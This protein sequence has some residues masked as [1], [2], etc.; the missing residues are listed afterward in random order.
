[1]TRMANYARDCRSA[2][3]CRDAQASV[4]QKWAVMA[5]GLAAQS[6]GGGGSVQ[7]QI[8]RQIQDLGLTFR[9]TGDADERPWPLTPMPLIVGAAE[10]GVVEAG[11]IQRAQLLEALAADIYGDQRL[12]RDGH[13]PAAVIAGSRYFARQMVGLKPQGG[14]YLRVCAFD[15]ARGPTGE[16]RILTDRLRLATGIGYAL[17]NRLALSRSTGA[18][19]DDINVRRLAA[20][21]AALREGMAQGC[22]R[23]QPRIALLT[24]ARFNQSYPEQAHLARYLGL[25]L[26]EGRD[27]T[28]ANDRLFVRT[29]AGPRRIDAVWRWI[30]TDALD[31]LS[32]DA[33][34]AI[35]VPD[36]FE[37]WAG[38]GLEMANWPGVEVMESNAFAA[39]LPKLCRVLLGEVALLPNVATWWCGQP[40]E[41][42]QVLGRLDELLVGPAFGQPVEVLN[43][44]AMRPGAEL[45][46]VQRD[47]LA[48]AVARRAMDYV[49]QE[50][51]HLSTSPVLIADRLVPRPFTLRAFAV[52][53]GDGQWTVMPGGFARL[54]SSGA[55]LTSLMGEGDLSADVCIVDDVPGRR[56][57]ITTIATI[58]GAP[59]VRRGG[60]ILA[61]Q[62]A[63]NLYWFGRYCERAEVTLRVLRSM[64]GSSIEADAGVRRDLEL[65]HLLADLLVEWDAIPETA[66]AGSLTQMCSAALTESELAGGVATLIRGGQR[67][68]LSLRDRLARD[69]WRIARRPPPAFDAASTDGARDAVKHLVERFGT[70]AGLIAENMVRDAA[71]RFLEIGRRIERAMLTCHIVR[72]LEIWADRTDAQSMLLDLCDSQII[73]RSRYLSAP[74]RDP[75]YDLLLLDPDNPRAL[76]FQLEAIERHVAALPSLANDAMPERPLREVRA[77]LA[78]LRGL[79]VD[80]L[81][82]AALGRIEAQLLALSDTISARYFLPPERDA[83]RLAGNLLG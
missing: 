78:P 51:V 27:L 30:D 47:E 41:A 46:A 79:T 2:D 66:T 73:Y 34:S 44:T 70:L 56:P 74:M 80:M 7:E 48:Q 5:D 4:A 65:R 16:W 57:A 69:F 28:V 40:G 37:A 12:V 25:P 32:F 6:H 33:R 76:M 60:G 26:V 58:L 22:A 9:M 67:V 17:E 10:W 49:G 68:G 53:G 3:L 1:M 23:E 31:P 83:S 72:H 24:P 29:I 77:L 63:D 45:S 71:F 75:V 21:Y 61:S 8:A 42:K 55:L 18:L 36:L 50:I 14:R 59:A 38:G 64:L 19:L 20:F 15:L 43:G 11:L 81:D 13:L 39:F 35:G 52:R 54:S 62:A 82:A